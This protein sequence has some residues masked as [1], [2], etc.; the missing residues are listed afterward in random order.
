MWTA[1]AVGSDGVGV[2]DSS[3]KP[4]FVVL[5]ESGTAAVL[6]AAE[7]SLYLWLFLG[8]LSG[9]VG[10]SSAVKWSAALRASVSSGT[11][12]GVSKGVSVGDGSG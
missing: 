2:W 9:S 12:L 4:L 8:S 7:A 3:G 6:G 1:A 5:L 10:V 11:D